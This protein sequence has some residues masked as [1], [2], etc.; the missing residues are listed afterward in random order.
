MLVVVNKIVVL[1][2]L[3][4]ETDN[5]VFDHFRCYRGKTNRSVVMR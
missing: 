1:Y 3:P 2:V 4:H 5:D